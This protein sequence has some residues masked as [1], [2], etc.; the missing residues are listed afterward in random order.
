MARTLRE[1]IHDPCSSPSHPC[2]S[3]FL[4]FNPA[5]SSGDSTHRKPALASPALLARHLRA[6]GHGPAAVR[7]FGRVEGLEIRLRVPALRIEVLP[8]PAVFHAPHVTDERMLGAE[9]LAHRLLEPIAG[10][11][12]KAI[13][14]PVA[15]R[16]VVRTAIEIATVRFCTE[17]PSPG[18]ALRRG[19]LAKAIIGTS[20]PGIG[21]DCALPG[22]FPVS[23]GRANRLYLR[24]RKRLAGRK[25]SA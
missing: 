11:A 7:G 10:R 8:A 2:S 17:A 24:K 1:R 9:L 12:T 6:G 20:A 23:G 4:A 21:G 5:R 16:N 13:A 18:A 14:A 15:T 3:V 19:R 25:Q 22:R